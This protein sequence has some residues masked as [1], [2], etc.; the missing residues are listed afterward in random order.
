MAD[1]SCSFA[2]GLSWQEH[3]TLI[4]WSAAREWEGTKVHSPLEVFVP[5][6]LLLGPP[7]EVSTTSQ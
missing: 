1:P 5:E 3:V 6:L 7:V 2:W 4:S